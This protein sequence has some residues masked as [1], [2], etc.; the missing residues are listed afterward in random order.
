MDES[1]FVFFLETS[2]R[3]SQSDPTDPC[4][5]VAP[6]GPVPD[7]AWPP[8]NTVTFVAAS[9]GECN[10]V[11][12][13]RG[14]GVFTRFL[15]RSVTELP[16]FSGTRPDEVSAR[17]LADYLSAKFHARAAGGGGPQRPALVAPN[18]DVVI[19]RLKAD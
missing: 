15:H 11:D 5:S 19:F 17:E 16:D 1:E 7:F 10:A 6:P 8:E 2:F 4:S 9:D 3:C 13:M 18:G 14:A 12:G